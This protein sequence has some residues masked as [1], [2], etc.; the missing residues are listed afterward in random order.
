MIDL[1]RADPA[2]YAPKQFYN[3]PKAMPTMRE[4][5][6]RL[7]HSLLALPQVDCPVRHYFAPGLYAREICIPKGTVLTGAVHKVENLVVLSAGKLRL[8]TEGGTVE[9]SAPHTMTCKPG[10]KNAAYALEDSIWTNF[11]ATNETDPDK[12]VEL[13]TESKAS[14]LL[15][16]CDNKQLM[17]NKAAELSEKESWHLE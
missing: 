17:A 1:E 11:F 7:E 6:Q 16:G 10:A 2:S 14:E 4:K 5:V 9:I 13:L 3:A 12:L 15:G 8:V